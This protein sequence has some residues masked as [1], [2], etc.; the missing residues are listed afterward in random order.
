MSHQIPLNFEF[1]NE[2]TF[3][4]FQIG[5]NQQIIT[6]LQQLIT[7]CD[8]SCVFL[9]GGSGIGKSH[10]LQATCQFVASNK[11]PVSFIPLKMFSQLSPALFEGLEQLPLVC[12][13]DVE[14]IGGKL[15]W[16]EGLFHLF[17]R[18][19][20][21]GNT[22]LV[23]GCS[24]PAHLPLQLADLKSRL[25]WG[26]VIQ[27]AAISDAQ[28]IIALQKRA[29]IRGMELNDEVG[30]FLLNHYSRDMASL[31][32]TLDLLDTASLSEHR[33]LTIQFVRQVLG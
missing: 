31:I 2:M 21:K 7:G 30:R 12:V 9:W 24:P 18:V 32:K 16:E 14:S 6:T 27:I 19:R 23:S 33:R 17:N 20:E 26:L 13:D 11:R 3:D 28:K 5:D 1:N 10:L 22:L 29:R 25:G 8:D 15:P 4:S